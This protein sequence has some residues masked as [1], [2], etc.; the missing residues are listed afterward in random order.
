MAKK[1]NNNESGQKNKDDNGGGKKK[2]NGSGGGGIGVVVV[3]KMDLHCKGCAAKVIKCVK[4]FDGVEWVKGSDGGEMNKLTV[5]GKVDPAKLQERLEKKTKKK[6]EIISPLPKKEKEKEKENNDREMK[7]NVKNKENSEAEE[8]KKN[9]KSEDNKCVKQ[10]DEKNKKNNKTEDKN[11]KKG[12]EKKSKEPPVTTVVLKLN[13]HCQGCIRKIESVVTKTKGY[14]EM[15]LDHQKYLLMVKGSMDPKLL[16][17]SLKKRLKRPV[18]IVP[19]KK[20]GS[21]EKGKG[22]GGS[23][24]GGGGSKGGDGG[25]GESKAEGGSGGK[26]ADDTG[27]RD[28]GSKG[29]VHRMEYLQFENPYPLIYGSGYLVEY[30]HAPQL[31]S[32]ENPNACVVM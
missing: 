10:R 14:K 19:S 31:F 8:K 6:V 4:S 17:E 32:D 12:D 25:N 24:G 16:V 29:E 15:S 3:L 27:G 18:E 7:A 30:V 22:G 13:W 11:V 1:G 28:G 5:A 20:E 26:G 9:H 21:G 2:E 23:K